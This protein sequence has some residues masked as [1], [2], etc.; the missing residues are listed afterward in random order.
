MRARGPRA[1]LDSAHAERARTGVAILPWVGCRR[2]RLAV[3]ATIGVHPHLVAG[4]TRRE[5]CASL[6]GFGAERRRGRAS[7]GTAAPATRTRCSCGAGAARRRGP[8]ARVRPALDL[9]RLDRLA[10][11]GLI[12]SRL[13]D[14]SSGGWSPPSASSSPF[15][16]GIDAGRRPIRAPLVLGTAAAALFVLRL[17]LDRVPPL[18]AAREERRSGAGGHAFRDIAR[19]SGSSAAW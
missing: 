10:M 2:R 18:A 1:V 4:R 6:V 7:R 11:G 8:D 13:S 16:G 12:A 14:G 15:P 3:L 9:F 5:R 17:H 19:C